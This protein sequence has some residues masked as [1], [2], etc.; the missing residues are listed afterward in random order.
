LGNSSEREYLNPRPRSRERDIMVSQ[1]CGNL[2]KI[3]TLEY[4]TN[5]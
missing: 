2:M 5:K 1:Y 4:H 3:L